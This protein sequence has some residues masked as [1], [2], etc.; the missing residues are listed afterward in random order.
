MTE[1]AYGAL[2]LAGFEALRWY[3]AILNT[4]PP[5]PSGY[6]HFYIAT[7]A[8]L[9]LF[10]GVVAQTLAVTGP[11]QAVYV[12]FSVPTTAEMILGTVKKGRGKGIPVDDVETTRTG[13]WGYLDRGFF[14]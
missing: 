11:A 13:F 6:W 7:L 10:A 9:L 8:I 3:R 4:R 2:G 14:G 12:G 5:V 1:F